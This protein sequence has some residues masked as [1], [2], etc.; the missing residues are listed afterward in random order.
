MFHDEARIASR[1]HHPNVVPVLDV[2][3][4]EHE[5]MLVQEYVHGVPL[6]V[7]MRRARQS[8]KPI[9]IPIA[10]AIVAYVLLAG[11]YAAHEA[12]DERGVPLDVIHR[13][14]SPQNVMLSVEGVPRLLDFG[15]AKARSSAHQTRAGVVKG[16][17]SYLSPE[18]IKLDP[19]TRR[20]DI[21]AAGVVLWELLANRR[22]SEGMGEGDFL[23]LLF[24]DAIPTLVEECSAWRRSMGQ[25]PAG[26]V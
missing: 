19:I 21:Y 26:N 14:V 20:V 11:L 4:T 6:S 12:R 8:L 9:P 13:D 16:K 23:A 7:L 22:V 3:V 17:L 5:V 24:D 18:Q 2:V 1:I 25:L 15:I 10:V